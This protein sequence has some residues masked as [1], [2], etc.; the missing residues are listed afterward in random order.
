MANLQVSNYPSVKFFD[1]LAVAGT[2]TENGFEIIV[3]TGERF[4]SGKIIFAT[5]IKDILPGIDGFKGC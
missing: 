3:E 4:A 1:G 5:G 2:K